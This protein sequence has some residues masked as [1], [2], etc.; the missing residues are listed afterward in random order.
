MPRV[1]DGCGLASDARLGQVA[2]LRVSHRVKCELGTGSE[3]G[4]VR[5]SPRLAGA[6]TVWCVGADRKVG[7]GASAER[8][9]SV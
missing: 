9:G 3:R 7:A 4:V 1:P 6:A 5:A 2:R 8:L